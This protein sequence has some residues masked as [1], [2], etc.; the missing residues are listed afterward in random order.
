LCSRL[1]RN[2]QLTHA[3]WLLVL[4][5]LVTPSIAGVPVPD[6]SAWMMADEVVD[7]EGPVIAVPT[8]NLIK[9]EAAS[10]P[11][12]K[13]APQTTPTV[14]SFPQSDVIN[15]EYALVLRQLE[16][17][18]DVLVEKQE[19][20]QR[21]ARLLDLE[22]QLVQT[23]LTQEEA[24]LAGLLKK[25]GTVSETDIEKQKLAV[26]QASLEVEKEKTVLEF[27]MSALKSAKTAADTLDARIRKTAED[28]IRKYPNH[29]KSKKYR[30]LFKPESDSTPTRFT[31]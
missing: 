25:G 10:S 1:K 15:T 23:K 20:L 26:K 31:N 7:S 14:R 22:V 27:K 5:K 18:R 17:T 29:F 2:P 19:S 3:L 21:D 4:I 12:S 13:P 11:S 16:L 28:F 8:G 24:T 30:E 6:F 9:K